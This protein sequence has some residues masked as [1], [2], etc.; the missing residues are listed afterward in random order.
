MASNRFI[1]RPIYLQV[2]DVLAGRIARGEWKPGHALPNESD[3]ARD[4]GVSAGTVRKALLLLES[5]QVL[6]RRQGRGT[7]VTD[8]A[9]VG[10]ADRFNGVRGAQGDIGACVIEVTGI[11]QDAASTAES[12]H[13]Q[14]KPGDL[15][16]RLYRVR[17]EG[18]RAF[19]C[20]HI[21][22]PAKLFPQIRADTPNRIVALAHA[23]GL[24]L[25]SSEE[26]VS[27]G[28]A[29][30]EVAEKLDVAP[31]TP[32]L[33]LDRVVRTTEGVPVEWRRAECHLGAGHYLARIACGG[34]QTV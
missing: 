25:G 27:L 30:A 13:L 29:S 10:L 3:L 8:P 15:V 11:A 33:A 24:L 23:H 21:A 12:L 19:M 17:R 18:K 6:M 9:A 5:H 2:C 1:Q 4:L 28:S 7:F 31:G 32:L 34:A 26:R 14:L 20:E 16:W 22:L